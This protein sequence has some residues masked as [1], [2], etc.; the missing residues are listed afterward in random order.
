MPSTATMRRRPVVVPRTQLQLA[1]LNE[2]IV[3]DLFAGGG[4]AS[5][6]IEMALGRQVDVAI[7]HDKE[8]VAMHRANHPQTRHYETDVFEVCPHRVVREHHGRPVGLLWLSPDCTFHSKARGSKPIRDRE[9]RRRALA[10]V[11][12]RWAGQVAPRVIMLENVEEFADWGPLVAKRDEETGRVIKGYRKVGKKRVPI[13]AAP[14]E[15]VPVEMQELVPDPERKGETFRQWVREMERHG[16]RVDLRELRACDYGAPTI[17]KRLFVVARRDGEPIV[18]PEPTHGDPSS[19]AVRRRRLLPWRTAAECLDWTE[20]VCSIFATKAEAKAW[21]KVHG[22]HS[23]NRP[24]AE[25]TMRRIARGVKR[26]VLDNPEPFIVPLTHH[27]SRRGHPLGEPVPTVTA[28]CRGELALVAPVVTHG[29]HGGASRPAN[30]PVHTI[31]ASTKDTNQAIEVRLRTA[32]V[33]RDYGQSVGHDARDPMGTLTA[34]ANGHAAVVS[35]FLA[36]N[37]AGFYKGDGRELDE[38]IGTVCASGSHQSLVAATLAKLRGTN[39]AADVEDPLHTISTGGNHA[40]VAAE[41]AVQDGLA[42][43]HLTHNYTSN[44]RGG[45]GDLD[46]PLKTVTSGQHAGLVAAFLTKYNGTATGQ[47]ADAPLDTATTTD[48]FGLVTVAVGGVEFIV[49]DIGLRMLQPRELY[50]ANG[51]PWT[52]GIDWGLTDEGDRVEFTKTAQVKM[53]GNAVP[54]Q[55]SAALVAANVPEMSARAVH[56]AA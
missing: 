40:V 35:A 7:N 51:F 29:Q 15:R 54:P 5:C 36:Q 39:D 8:A 31:A 27:G 55:F 21:G 41:L 25:N 33:Q 12:V 28:A 30:A 10:W 16:Y 19:A 20:P 56:F 13:V 11:G 49:V 1:G 47:A 23:P 45:E 26:Y 14:G 37:N 48:R 52:Y 32:H 18:W 3:V 17:R 53:C 43:A 4:G 44:T 42:A 50:N 24:L 38:P 22:R 9:K 34:G 46:R 2:E 6:G